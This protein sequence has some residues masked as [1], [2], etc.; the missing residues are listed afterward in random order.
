MGLFDCTT[1]ACR[2]ESKSTCR[3]PSIRCSLLHFRTPDGP[4]SYRLLPYHTSICYKPATPRQI[5]PKADCGCTP[6]HSTLPPL[7]A[8]PVPA[9]RKWSLKHMLFFRS[10]STHGCGVPAPPT[11]PPPLSST[12]HPAAVNTLLTAAL[13]SPSCSPLSTSSIPPSNPSPLLRPSRPCAVTAA[14][15]AAA[16]ESTTCTPPPAPAAI[17]S[18]RWCADVLYEAAG[19]WVG[20]AGKDGAWSNSKDARPRSRSSAVR[21]L[22][23]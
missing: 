17:L 10:A 11:P 20:L 19:G 23:S 9:A 8:A 4:S 7:A 3:W 12:T 18:I 6:F 1:A 22:G 13:D 15:A 5:L 16:S 21:S 14:G 2:Q